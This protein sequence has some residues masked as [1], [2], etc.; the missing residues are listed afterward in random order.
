MSQLPPSYS[1]AQVR[2]SGAQR[3]PPSRNWGPIVAI[4]IGPVLLFLLLLVGVVYLLA[5]NQ[6]Q[7]VHFVNGLMEAYSVR[8]GDREYRLDPGQPVG[9]SVRQGDVRVEIVDGPLLLQ[10]V[11][12][13]VSVPL[14]EGI[15]NPPVFV[16]NPDRMAILV[17]EE[18]Q[19][20]TGN[21]HNFDGTNT[22]HTGRTL[23]R[24]PDVDH[25]F[26]DFPEEIDLAT[27]VS[28]E[29]RSRLSV[30]ESTDP[31]IA[32]FFLMINEG[33]EAAAAYIRRF[34]DFY[35]AHGGMLSMAAYRL[36]PEDYLERVRPQLDV[37]PANEEIHLAYIEFMQFREEA[38]DL[39]AEYLARV[40]ANPR[41]GTLLYLMSRV[42]ADQAES[43]KLLALAMQAP[44]PSTGAAFEA[45]R[46]ALCRG[47]FAEAHRLAMTG[48]AMGSGPSEAQRFV[49]NEAQLAA[50]EIEAYVESKKNAL[51]R[52]PDSISDAAD[53][54][55]I[56]AMTNR[57]FLARDLIEDFSENDEMDNRE[58]LESRIPLGEGRFTE[59]FQA[60]AKIWDPA[61]DFTYQLHVGNSERA[62]SIL[63]DYGEDTPL[64]FLL[65]YTVAESRRAPVAAKDSLRRAVEELSMS[66]KEHQVLA[67]LLRRPEPPTV[68]E[69]R[70]LLLMPEEKAVALA[71]LGMHFPTIR[72][73]AFA[74]ARHFNYRRT[75]KQG[76]LQGIIGP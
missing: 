13:T 69:L 70:D 61:T 3:R 28:R 9:V 14:V 32:V 10:P 42:V 12:I 2:T 26:E 6:T 15:M 60:T 37:L 23:H 11:T 63:E 49:L 66:S 25:L 29:I 41:N 43:D 54:V 18:T 38:A 56:Y 64:D 67:E 30:E 59:Y 75:E 24:F 34:L 52:E 51:A 72:E 68:E 35:P 44:E 55:V 73:M 58:W 20:A 27:P 46:R 74:Q 76:I 7:T 1:S 47:E 53:L 62:F 22:F 48:A 71:A 31:E 19:Y 16:A 40:T 4:A 39:E 21:N 17:Y 33:E 5:R 45:A 50:G 36:P 8:V 65:V 57:S